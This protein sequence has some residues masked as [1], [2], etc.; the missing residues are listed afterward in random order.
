MIY[1]DPLRPD[2][3]RLRCIHALFDGRGE[4]V[5]CFLDVDI[6]LGGHLKERDA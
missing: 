4:A 5:E 3:F 1:I 6:I 2:L